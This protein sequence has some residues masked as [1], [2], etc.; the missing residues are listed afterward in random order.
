MAVLNEALKMLREIVLKKVLSENARK[1]KAVK[2]H[3]CASLLNV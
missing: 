1:P 2:T 3:L